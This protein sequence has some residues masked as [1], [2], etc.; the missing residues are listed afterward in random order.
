MSNRQLI[1]GIYAAFG[2]GDVPTVLGAFDPKIEWREAESN[3]Y[4]MSGKPWIGGEA[5]TQ[6]LFVKLAEE[7]DGF[8]VTPRTYHD[9]GDSVVVEGRYTGTHETTGKSLDA[10]FCHVWRVSGGRVT[11]FQQYCD[12]ARMQD[13]T[14]TR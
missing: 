9:A 6:N 10:Q 7:W 3:P 13:A 5:I 14:G 12:T 1:E 8:T 4:E 11:G 2:K